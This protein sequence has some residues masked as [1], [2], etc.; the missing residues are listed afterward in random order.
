MNDDFDDTVTTLRILL[1]FSFKT[2]TH[3]QTVESN[4]PMFLFLF[5]QEGRFLVTFQKRN[6]SKCV[7]PILREKKKH[8][9]NLMISCVLKS[10]G[11]H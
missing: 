11:L 3:L 9:L 5:H 1:N 4:L 2:D 8:L 10:S 6:R 7:C